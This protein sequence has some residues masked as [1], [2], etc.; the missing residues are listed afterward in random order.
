MSDKAP[1]STEKMNNI[2]SVDHDSHKAVSVSETLLR[3]A[4]EHSLRAFLEPNAAFFAERFHAQ[5]PCASSA[6]LLAVVY[7]NQGLLSQAIDVLKPYP[8]MENRYLS[9]VCHFRIGSTSSLSE[10]ETLLRPLSSISAIILPV[11]IDDDDNT[12]PSRAS[13]MVDVSAPQE[14]ALPVHAHVASSTPGGAA[15][16]YLLATIYQRTGRRDSAISFYRAALKV[17]PTFWVAFEALTRLVKDTESN[18]GIPNVSDQ[19]A[20]TILRS[21]PKFL[22]G[23]ILPM[24]SDS[25]MSDQMSMGATRHTVHPNASQ[26][27]PAPRPSQESNAVVPVPAFHSDPAPHR[28]IPFH[29]RHTSQDV[30]RAGST[31]E[32]LNDTSQTGAYTRG[33]SSMDMELGNA[34]DEEVHVSLPSRPGT[35][36]VF[37]STGNPTPA[38]HFQPHR[39]QESHSF[40]PYSDHEQGTRVNQ[41][42][43]GNTASHAVYVPPR[44]RRPGPP[45]SP[46]EL[47]PSRRAR[48]LSQHPF[49]CRE[50]AGSSSMAPRLDHVLSPSEP[51]NETARPSFQN[52]SPE[53]TID[54]RR[55]EIS[56]LPRAT[57][58]EVEGPSGVEVG[59]GTLSG[60][61]GFRGFAE[62]GRARNTTANLEYEF[63]VMNLIKAI[64]Q[65]CVEVGRYRCSHAL[66]ASNKLPARHR[67]TGLVLSLRGRAL[68]DKGD[69]FAAEKEFLKATQLEPS[70][71]SG[72]VEY[73]ATVL[74]H[75]KKE[76]E[77]AAL[78]LHSQRVIP[79]SSA[80]S[81]AAGNCHSLLKDTDKAIQFFQSAISLSQ[82]ACAYAFTMCGHEHLAKESLDS[83]LECYHAAL[84]IDDRHYNAFFGIGQVMLKH[85]KHTRAQ[86]YLQCAISLNPSNSNLHYHL[87]F[88]MASEASLFVNNVDNDN[89]VVQDRPHSH[90]L[91]LA[92][93]AELETAINLDPKSVIPRFERGKVLMAM[94]RLPEARAQLE[95]L[96][97]SLPREAA[98]HYELGR[99]YLLMGDVQ[100]AFLSHSAATDIEPNERKYRN[101]LDNLALRLGT[102]SI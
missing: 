18:L 4:V 2:N 20:L 54:I 35:S 47:P 49:L 73:Y 46:S 41:E 52:P 81:C 94:R 58:S 85:G 101:A 40:L 33:N 45:I 77:L 12:P 102:M 3:E 24:D 11:N 97:N 93:L 26:P 25:R 28:Q 80:A 19:E 75:L 39:R 51:P 79:L 62:S 22:P 90:R 37:S 56:S 42:A 64:G 69:F 67:D 16:L 68:L 76:K 8:S 43:S 7:L 55:S 38:S 5:S 36:N 34:V 48:T 30:F 100:N 66:E 63:S 86:R 88:A 84:D 70:R 31:D 57:Y 83:A 99:V 78:S 82:N 61:N 65:V 92:A 89:D 87:G 60:S 1:L 91:M 53:M 96:R 23:V 17:N 15:G 71:M 95:E 9:A 10:A 50:D 6:N 13:A 27:F 29:A 98:V 32:A 21:Q 44:P 14:A 74:W 59:T 72:I